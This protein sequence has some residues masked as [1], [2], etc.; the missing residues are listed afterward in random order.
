MRF[1]NSHEVGA[2]PREIAKLWESGCFLTE[3]Y[4]SMY[5][6]RDGYSEEVLGVIDIDDLNMKLVTQKFLLEEE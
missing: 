1:L 6:T 5:E 4:Y 2:T 3:D